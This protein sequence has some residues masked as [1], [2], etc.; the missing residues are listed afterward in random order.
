[1]GSRVSW[2]GDPF[3]AQ[4]DVRAVYEVETSAS[5][6]M[7]SQTSAVDPQMQQRYMQE[8]PFLVYLNIDGELMEPKISFGL[9]MPENQQ[10]AVGG[11]IY[12]RVQQLSNQEQE[13][14][15]QVFS[16]LVLNRFFPESGSSGAGG[17]TMAV[18]RDNLNSALSD[19]LNMLSS[20]IMGESGLQL[21]FNVDSFT[22]YQGDSPQDRTQ[23]GISAQKAF[24][25]DRLVVEVG[26]A[27]DIQGGNEAGQEASPVIGNVSISYLLDENGIWRIKGFS[28]SKFENVIDGQLVVSGIA[29]IFTKEF[30]KFKNMFE[31]AVM[32]NVQKKDKNP[33]P[34][35]KPENP[36]DEN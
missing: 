11:K 30:N 17:G 15:K 23:L 10:G 29:L 8:L 32:E 16:L 12:G 22:D 31:K 24:M 13:L 21:N 7:A 20:R 3:E 36:E 35:K 27:V 5:S 1:D 14:N 19:Q 33:E 28:R 6:L 26:S 2:A 34:A 25:D 9:D 18:A 4:L